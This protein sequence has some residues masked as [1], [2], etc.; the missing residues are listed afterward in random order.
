VL[1]LYVE[2]NVDTPEGYDPTALALAEGLRGADG[3]SLIY[4]PPSGGACTDLPLGLTRDAILKA[5]RQVVMVSGCGQGAAWPGLVFDWNDVEVEERNHGY[6]D[7]PVCDQDPDGDGK[8]A[9]GPDV[10][11][12]KLVRYYEDSTWVS[13]MASNAGLASTDDGLS[14]ETTRRMVRCGV[15]LIGFDQILP[16]DGRL[17][18]LAWSWAANE[19]SRAGDCAIQRA[20]G[21][22]IA[23]RCTKRHQ[24]ACLRP[25]GSWAVTLV[26]VPASATT[27]ACRQLSGKPATPRTGAENEALRRVAASSG[28]DDVWVV[29][30]SG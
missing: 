10:Y 5:G 26:S 24:A 19:P 30:Q 25:D 28:A 1:L 27:A 20:D 12:S 2:D 8:P 3:K 6:R 21:R 23:R 22:W 14:P 4:K 16:T 7:Y 18:A 9:F 11:A 29:A 17:K 15:D 13:P